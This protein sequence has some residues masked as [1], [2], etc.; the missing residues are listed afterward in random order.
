[1]LYGYV[2]NGHLEIERI[3]RLSDDLR[4]LEVQGREMVAQT[5]RLKEAH[6]LLAD[7]WG[8]YLGQPEEQLQERQGWLVLTKVVVRFLPPVAAFIG[9]GECRHGRQQIRKGAAYLDYQIELPGR[10]LD[11]FFRWV[12]RFMGYAQILEPQDLAE[13]HRLAAL[14]LVELYD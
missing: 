10:S 7:G 13:R 14:K 12:C 2:Q 4:I 6:Q 9:E 8:L 3:D 1:L 11:E 5:H